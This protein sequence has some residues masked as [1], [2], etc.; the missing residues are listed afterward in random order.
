M[1]ESPR[2]LIAR[3]KTSKAISSLK[4]I[5]KFNG[6]YLPENAQVTISKEKEPPF[7]ELFLSPIYRRRIIIISLVWFSNTLIYYG[8]SLSAGS[9]VSSI[10][11]EFILNAVIEIPAT[12]F[13]QFTMHFISRKKSLCA[14]MICSGI[15]LMIIMPLKHRLTIFIL[16]LVGKFF[17]ST[18][19]TVMLLYTSELF[20]TLIRN[21][22]FGVASCSGRFGSLLSTAISKL[23]HEI[24]VHI[25][26][27]SFGILSV[28]IGASVLL[29]QETKDA[30]LKETIE[31]KVKPEEDEIALNI[32]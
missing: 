16:E 8:L 21:W 14:S 24:D 23:S 18:A 1:P 12:A 9:F 5:A 10:Y 22:A 29:L 30:L 4:F 17:L 19:F 20:P 32:Q 26:M 25:P 31:K 27:F 6:K 13:A 3:K 11:I 28:V 2:W 15:C 7:C